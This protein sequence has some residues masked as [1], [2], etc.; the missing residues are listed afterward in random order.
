MLVSFLFFFGKQKNT[1][2]DDSQA[3]S[4]E[5]QILLSTL[6]LISCLALDKSLSFCILVSHCKTLEQKVQSWLVSTFTEANSYWK[7]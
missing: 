5:M 7:D 2:S 1:N 6:P 3:R 4:Q